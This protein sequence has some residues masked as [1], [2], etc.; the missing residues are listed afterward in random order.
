MAQ[1]ILTAIFVVFILVLAVM[2]I[3]ATMRPDE[4]RIERAADIKAPPEKIFAL[5]NDFKA[6]P[7]WSPWE[8][9]DPNMRRSYGAT[10]SGPGAVYEW[11]GDK[12]IGKGRMTIVDATPPSR[13]AIDL[14]FIKPFTAR[15][16]VE[17]MLE[18]RGDAT[19]VTWTM[20]GR[21]SLLFKIMHL[22]IDM[23]RMVGKDIEQGFANLKAA[24]ER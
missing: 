23:D 7:A 3:Y 6:W 4:F 14:H 22:F 18:P 20:R 9:K 1:M 2:F 24:T 11:D 12:N 5:I 19:H 15:N 13:V 10:A 8:K 16:T 17:F 21:S